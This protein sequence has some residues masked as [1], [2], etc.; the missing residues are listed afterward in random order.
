MESL[1][2]DNWNLII[3]DVNLNTRLTSIWENHPFEERLFSPMYPEKINS[4]SILF[5]GL[6]PSVSGKPKIDNKPTSWYMD[7]NTSFE[8]SCDKPHRHFEKFFQLKDLISNKT[9]ESFSYSY[10]DLLYWQETNSKKVKEKIDTSFIIEQAKLSVEIISKLKPRLVIVSNS[11]AGEILYKHRVPINFIAELKSEVY[12][13]ERIPLIID[14][15]KFM[16]SA[17]LWNAKKGTGVGLKI[18]LLEEIQKILQK[19]ED[20]SNPKQ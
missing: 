18:K 20:W 7:F 17:K 14:Q 13:F 4:N 3:Q 1:N 2:H 10:M 12:Q 15:S 11:L 9:K 8:K 19:T 6:N 16:G 5:L